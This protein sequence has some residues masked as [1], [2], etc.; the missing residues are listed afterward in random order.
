MKHAVENSLAGLMRGYLD[1]VGGYNESGRGLPHSTTWRNDLASK[2]ARERLGTRQSCAAERFLFSSSIWLWLRCNVAVF[3]VVAA[4]IFGALTSYSQQ[5]T[6]AAATRK[7][8]VIFFL[9][10]DL[11]W[12]DLGYE[13]SKVYHT[14]NIDAFSKSAVRFNRAYAACPVCSPT[15]ASILTGEY[16]ARLHLS[17]WLPGRKDF[18]FQKLKNVQ[19][20]QHLPYDQ[21]TLPSVLKAN[22]YKTAIFGK[23][24]LG[25]EPDSTARQGFDLH[26]PEWNRGWPNGT[27]FSPYGMKGLEGGPDG[28]YLTDRLTTEALRWV[29]KNKDE[30]FFL[31]LAH[32]A[33]HDPIMGRADLVAKYEKEM[34]AAPRLA[35]PPYILEPNPDDGASSDR[36]ELNALLKEKRY[37]G[38]SLLPD[39]MVKIKQWQNNPQFAGM[40]ESMDESLG[41]VLAALKKLKLDDNTIVIFFS[42]NGGMSAANFGNPHRGIAKTKLDKT[43]STSNL[44]LRGGKGWLYEGGVREPLLIYWPHA[45]RNGTVTDVPAISTDFYKTIL[46][47]VGIHAESQASDGIDGKSLVP[48]LNGDQK[49][50]SKLN[51]RPIYW[52]WPHYS[53]HGAQSPGGAVLQG[54]YKLIEYYESN[55]AQLFNLKTDPSEQNDL[56]SKEPK[57]VAE[58]RAMFHAWRNDVNAEMPVPNPK[59]DPNQKWPDGEEQDEP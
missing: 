53:N 29:E 35:G 44:P 20:A 43:Y 41:R 58:L 37:Q 10:D 12:S 25:E 23:W 19:S 33:V 13:G 40:V 2:L 45:A 18:P 8:N 16:P 47:M 9:V 26:V 5:P 22:G 42:D 51:D 48:V 46:D 1:T 11:G 56:A 49:A 15:R 7:P 27:Y 52:H 24:H 54:N 32:F 17:D 34:S 4:A 28:E 21:P 59:F 39:R 55:T 14:P 38:F 30:P 31:Y 6:H 3:L 57:K 36:A 50:A